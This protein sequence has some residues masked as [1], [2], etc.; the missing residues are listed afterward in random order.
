[1]QTEAETLVQSARAATERCRELKTQLDAAR[2]EVDAGKEA[3]RA[4]QQELNATRA[5][6]EGMLKVIASLEKRVGEAASVEE[7]A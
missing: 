1:M 7:A 6:A 5:D 3:V 4:C 2:A